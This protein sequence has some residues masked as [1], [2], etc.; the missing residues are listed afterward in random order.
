MVAKI[1]LVAT[2]KNMKLVPRN[3]YHLDGL[4]GVGASA[5]DIHT[6]NLEL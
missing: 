1:W 3:T 2:H 6:Y 5:T 4:E